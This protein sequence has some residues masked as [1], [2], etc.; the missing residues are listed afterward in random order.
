MLRERSLM[1]AL[2]LASTLIAAP[3]AAQ[4]DPVVEA[5]SATA[6]CLSAVI[7]GAPVEDIDGDNVTIRRGKEPVSC[8]VRVGAGEPVVIHDAVMTAL[9]R[10]A[11]AFSP[12]KTRW[13]AGTWAS[14]ETFCSLPGRR[15][16]AVF[17]S[18][19]KPGLQPVL[20]A[21]VFES[22]ERDQRCDRDL[23][24]QTVAAAAAPP[25]PVAPSVETATAAEPAR[26]AAPPSKPKK[27][28]WL[29]RLPGLGRKD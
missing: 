21:T 17:V 25:P 1:R 29:P 28:G 8:T 19:A 15:S 11:E 5:R 22:K 12:A 18:T 27:K 24:I 16:F 23:G 14:R 6:A 9:R 2:I 26:A 4:S 20:T 10:R 3:A 13:E 7:D